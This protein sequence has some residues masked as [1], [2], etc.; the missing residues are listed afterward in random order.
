MDYE[1]QNLLTAL[2]NLL[3]TEL[4]LIFQMG[5]YVSGNWKLKPDVHPV[6]VRYLVCLILL[7]NGLIFSIDFEE[8]CEWFYTW[9]TP[10]YV[11]AVSFLLQQ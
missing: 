8:Y 1:V 9:P 3:K 7:H 10:T 2:L 6:K 11:H 4:L 5:S